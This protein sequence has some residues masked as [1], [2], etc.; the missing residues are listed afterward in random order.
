[1]PKQPT[2]PANESPRSGGPSALQRRAQATWES[3]CEELKQAGSQLIRD[4]LPLGELDAA[5]GLRYLSRLLRTG[6]ER[7]VEAADPAD[8]FLHSLCDERLKG[9]GGD[10][11]DSLYFGATIGSDHVY[12]LS[13]DFRRCV[14]LSL[15]A[16]GIDERGSYRVTG[17]LDSYSLPEARERP[18]EISIRPIEGGVSPGASNDGSPATS[19]PTLTT[20]PETTNLL[21]R[22]TFASVADKQSLR[23]ELSRVDE[24]GEPIRVAFE[25][26]AK[27]LLA[28]ARFVRTTAEQWTNQSV[29]LRQRFNQLPLQDP[30]RIR[31]A[32]G[33]PSVFY[34]GAAWSV[35]EDEFL[36]IRLSSMP[37]TTAWGFQLNNLWTESLDY[38]QAPIHLNKQTAHYDPDG[39]VTIVVSERDP[40]H[41]NWLRTLGHR[42]GTA[43]LRLMGAKKPVETE[44]RV[45]SNVDEIAGATRGS[46]R[47]T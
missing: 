1:M 36:V 28:T 21:V 44:V 2:D 45:V 37:E 32:G 30:E 24:T 14:H 6:L 26:I 46:L 41:P 25:P 20:T 19:I 34:Y 18:I 31:K 43:N 13:G 17:S 47:P 27:G 12:R 4:D 11:P 16:S 9:F 35:A 40:G 38:T 3:F 29:A 7:H 33:D 39:G 5:E 10:N 42:S 23:L 8:V 22:C 15:L